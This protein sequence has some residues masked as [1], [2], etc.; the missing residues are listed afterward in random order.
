MKPNP[1]RVRN[2]GTEAWCEVCGAVSAL[3]LPAPVSKWLK[4][5][6]AFVRAHRACAE[7]GEA[8]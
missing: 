3:P 5:A 2:G 1:T 8:R 4:A 6:R 7:G